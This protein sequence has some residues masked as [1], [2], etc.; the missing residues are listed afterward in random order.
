[1]RNGWTLLPFGVRWLSIVNSTFRCYIVK[2][3]EARRV[4]ILEYEKEATYRV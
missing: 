2:L 4:L 1:M 3:I